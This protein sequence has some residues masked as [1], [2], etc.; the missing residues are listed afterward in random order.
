[1]TNS[2]PLTSTPSPASF[3][4]R[5]C[6]T[7]VV[8]L[9]RQIVALE[10]H[11]QTNTYISGAFWRQSKDVEFYPILAWYTRDMQ[12]Q[13]VSSL[14]NRLKASVAFCQT[15]I[16]PGTIETL[17]HKPLKS[18]FDNWEHFMLLVT[19]DVLRSDGQSWTSPPGHFDSTSVSFT[20][21][22]L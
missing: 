7:P 17:V 22:L 3:V 6:S 13:L 5:Q 9:R 20:N 16:L 18:S 11:A 10:T 4:D 21:L 12:D 14:S 1:M 2:R 8:F 15:L 19:A